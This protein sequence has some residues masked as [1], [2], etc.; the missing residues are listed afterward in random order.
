LR[1]EETPRA[2]KTIRAILIA[3]DTTG[4]VDDIEDTLEAFRRVVGGYIEAVFA[5]L[6]AAVHAASVLWSVSAPPGQAPRH[7]RRF[8]AVC[9]VTTMRLFIIG[10]L[11]RGA[12]HQSGSRLLANARTSAKGRFPPAYIAKGEAMSWFCAHDRAVEDLRAG[13]EPWFLGS[14]E[15]GEI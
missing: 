3:P 8:V 2:A 1:F 10:F 13:R 11:A 14:C 7:D 6:L 4:M 5:R 9:A 12:T 15:Q